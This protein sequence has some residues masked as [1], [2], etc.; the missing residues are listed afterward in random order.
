[1]IKVY[2]FRPLYNSQKKRN[3]CII[4]DRQAIGINRYRAASVLV[5][6]SFNRLA[7]RGL[8]W[9]EYNHG[10]VPTDESLRVAKTLKE[11]V[12]VVI[13]GDGCG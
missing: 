8:A 1:L 5:A 6:K 9:R 10:I 2:G 3:G 11:S 12:A 13:D 7:R 4:F